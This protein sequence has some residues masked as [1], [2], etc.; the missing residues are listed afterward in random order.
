MMLFEKLELLF[1]DIYI[2]FYPFR[3]NFQSDG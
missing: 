1:L 2:L 3:D